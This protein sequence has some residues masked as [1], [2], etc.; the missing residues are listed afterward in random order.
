MLHSSR[1]DDTYLAGALGAAIHSPFFFV[2]VHDAVVDANATADFHLVS[3]E[4]AF[5][6]LKEKRE[7][8]LLRMENFPRQSSNRNESPTDTV[9]MT[10][11]ETSGA[12]QMQTTA[13]H[14]CVFTWVSLRTWPGT[15]ITATSGYTLGT[16]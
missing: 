3:D 11:L 10:L 1:C 14:I 12:V 2:I 9:I 16:C 8:E 6:R 4:I 15:A 7:K 5:L 13:K